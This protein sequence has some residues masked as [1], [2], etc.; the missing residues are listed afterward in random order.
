MNEEF[1]LLG[2]DGKALCT[3][4]DKIQIGLDNRAWVRKTASEEGEIDN[5]HRITG[6]YMNAGYEGRRND[7]HYADIT[8][9]DAD[10][11]VY[12]WKNRAG[13]IWTLTKKQGSEDTFMVGETC[14][15]YKH[16]YEK[17][18]LILKDDGTVL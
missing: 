15:Y 16:G 4:G 12:K 10:R 13:V 5:R 2:L 17:A 1:F 9:H 7:W 18:K 14:P 8:V 3:D 11:G 6:S